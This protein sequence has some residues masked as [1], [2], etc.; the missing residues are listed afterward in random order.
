MSEHTEHSVLGKRI[1]GID[2]HEKVSGVA[3]FTADMVLPNMLYGKILRS[4]M[5]TPRLSISISVKPKPSSA[6]KVWLPVK[7][8]WERNRVSGGVSRNFATKN[9]TVKKY[10][11]SATR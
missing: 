11:L 1:P 7:T 3:K 8:P 2:S 4:P 10:A 6:L 5:H 9:S